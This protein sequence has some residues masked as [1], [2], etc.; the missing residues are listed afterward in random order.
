MTTAA[1]IDG[2]K[3]LTKDCHSSRSPAGLQGRTRERAAGGDQEDGEEE[4]S[5]AEF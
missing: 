2:M 3:C 1:C 5:Q 4:C